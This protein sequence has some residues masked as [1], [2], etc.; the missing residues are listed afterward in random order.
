MILESFDVSTDEFARAI[1]T[2]APPGHATRTVDGPAEMLFV[3][4][5]TDNRWNVGP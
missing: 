1:S 2:A 3:T 5:K 4:L